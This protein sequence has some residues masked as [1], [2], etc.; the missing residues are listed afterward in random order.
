[1]GHH[2]AWYASQGAE[3]V[4]LS[5]NLLKV[6]KAVVTRNL[7]DMRQSFY[8]GILFY[9]S[10]IGAAKVSM[11]LQYIQVFSISYPRFVKLCWLL[12][13]TQI[14]QTLLAML[15]SAFACSPTSAFWEDFGSKDRCLDW[16]VILFFNASFNSESALIHWIQVFG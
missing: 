10:T 6:W 9:Y 16:P 4:S 3:G 2:L 13:V 1:M 7:I 15:V 12:L 5:T 11:L 8:A 14:L